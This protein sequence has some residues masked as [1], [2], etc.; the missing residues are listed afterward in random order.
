MSDGIAPFHRGGEG[1]PLVILHGFTGSWRV[2]RHLL[3]SLE[4][5]HDVFAPSLLGHAGG[6]HPEPGDEVS[7][8]TIADDM[9]RQFD[10]QGIEQAHIAG[11][12]LGGWLS[13]ELGRRGRALSVVAVS[14]AGGWNGRRELDRVVKMMRSSVAM[15]HRT[16]A[17]S[18]RLLKQAWARRMGLRTVAER[19]DRVSYED[20]RDLLEDARACTI[21]DEFLSWIINDRPLPPRETDADYPITIGWA[22][23]DRVLPFGRYGR[24]LLENIGPVELMR[25]PGCGHVPMLDDPALVAHTILTTTRR[26]DEKRKA[27]TT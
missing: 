16:P 10:E 25:L 17:L 11:N 12:S 4:E 24:P 5:E 22:D 26:V 2:W 13:L 1:S 23:R 27:A 19:G 18:D 8:R 21:V 20:A 9:E 14:P 6:V 3:P 15:A 7:I